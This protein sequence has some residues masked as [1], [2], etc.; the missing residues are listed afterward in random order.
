M[1]WIVVELSG[2]AESTAVICCSVFCHTF[3]FWSWM[4]DC[5]VSEDED[6]EEED[7]DEDEEEDEEL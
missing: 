4:Y 3:P 2:W 1:N 5:V 7:E 6:N